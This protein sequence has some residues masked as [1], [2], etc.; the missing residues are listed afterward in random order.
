MT[1]S[2]I[3]LSARAP[4]VLALDAGSSSV[5]AGL[6]D[7]VG[8]PLEGGPV[9]RF[10]VAWRTSPEGAMEA[11]GEALLAACAAAVDGAME[12]A[13]RA[14]I[15]VAAVAVAT[16]WH[17]VMGVGADGRPATPLYGWGDTRAREDAA[18]LRGRVDA[19]AAHG[20]TGCFVHEVYPAAK[21]VWLRRT[22]GDTF[23]RVAAWGSLG[24]LLALRLFGARRT[25]VSMASGT[26]LLD[27]RA[28]RWDAEMMAAAGV[29][30]GTLPEVSDAPLVGLLPE[31]ARRWPGLAGVP[32]VPALGDGACA[33]LGSGARGGR[34]ALTVGTSAA[35]RVLRAEADPPVPPGLWCYRLDARRAV[36][37]RALSNAGNVHA[38]LRR[39][40]RLPEGEELDRA[41][42]SAEA[43]GHGLLVWP[44]LVGERP[45]LEAGP[46]AEVRGLTLAT[47]PVQIARAWLEAAAV[48]MAEALDAVEAAFGPADEVVAG[49]GALHA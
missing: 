28:L 38:W 32:W 12:V 4:W 40:L 1:D 2:A 47:T 17:G 24:E 43:R 18:R 30:E 23:P 13:G 7:A 33:S 36:W 3:S 34:V 11:D 48:G 46:G 39:T 35:V 41:L 8:R 14:G 44:E 42:A 6:Y 22:L 16:F 21:L 19:G 25:S 26:G 9:A 20:R 10:R 49:G 27:V 31:Y 29:E 5:R 45:P 15:E 37:G